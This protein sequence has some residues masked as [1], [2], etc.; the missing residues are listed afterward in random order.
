MWV[1]T[2]FGFLLRFISSIAVTMTSS[3]DPP[4][5]TRALKLFFFLKNLEQKMTLIGIVGFGNL[6]QAIYN[7]CKQEAHLGEVFY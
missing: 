6:G 2:H 1:F 4:R 5:L 7:Y 3:F